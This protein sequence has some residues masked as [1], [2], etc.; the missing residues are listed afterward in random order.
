VIANVATGQY[1]LR[2]EIK[3]EKNKPLPNAKIFVHSSRTLFTSGATAGDF[4]INEKVLYDS[5]I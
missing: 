4:G 1:Y 3:D 2:G 5:Y